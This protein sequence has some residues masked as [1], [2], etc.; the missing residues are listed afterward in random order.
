L[1][2]SK[3]RVWAN[4]PTTKQQD[5]SEKSTAR[6]MICRMEKL[7][8]RMNSIWDAEEKH[9]HLPVRPSQRLSDGTRLQ[10]VPDRKATTQGSGGAGL[11]GHVKR[12]A[13]IGTSTSTNA[14]NKTSTNFHKF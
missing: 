2:I 10:H 1:R 11:Y 14:N 7:E 3:E 13:P 12:V 8:R 6:K 5:Q 4:E 9:L